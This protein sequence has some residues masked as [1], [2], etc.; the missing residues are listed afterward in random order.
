[1][2]AWVRD[3]YGS[4]EQLRLADVPVPRPRDDEVLVRVR[5]VSLNGSDSEGLRGSPGYARMGG[6][7]RPRRR[8][9]GSDIAGTVER[10]G[11]KVTRFAV[12]DEVFGDNLER[13]GGLAELAVARERA[14][15]RMPDG[16]SFEEAAA[17]PQGGV[18]ALQ[19]L[20]DAAGLRPGQAVLVN[21]A[22][23]SAGTFAVQLAKHFGAVVTAVDSA[24]K[25]PFLRKLGAD[26]T[27]DYAR[28]DFTRTGARY[29]LILDV[30]ARRSAS[31]YLRALRP[32]GSLL[33][34]GGP[35]RR[36]LWLLLAGLVVRPFAG[37]RLRVLVV[38]RSLADLLEV[39][40]LCRAGAIRPAIGHEFGFQETPD[41]FR[42]L[43]TGQALGKIVLRIPE[44]GRQRGS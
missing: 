19:G 11:A 26:E 36:M 44:D 23:G 20:R 18:I 40:E 35:V 4:P 13:L 1:V 12:G 42:L 30:F 28:R 9:L 22:G 14:L 2:K 17:L 5:A 3:R 21:G 31:D 8:I 15:A 41:A 29:D 38:R 39:A 43:V 37:R 16:L 32:G 10:V 25:L 6:L 27:I 7:F 24:P 33:F 34:V